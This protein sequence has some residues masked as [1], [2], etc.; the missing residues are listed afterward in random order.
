ME[1]SL[2][3]AAGAI[4][5]RRTEAQTQ[6]AEKRVGFWKYAR[7]SAIRPKSLSVK[8]QDKKG[9]FGS[10]FSFQMAKPEPIY[11]LK[12]KK[13]NRNSLKIQGEIQGE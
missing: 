10:S 6:G 11:R 3:T 8:E 12:R 9:G 13:Q 4:L 5:A 7:K 1:T 2:V